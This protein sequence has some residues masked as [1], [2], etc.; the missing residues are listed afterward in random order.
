MFYFVFF[1]DLI[2][3]CVEHINTDDVIGYSFDL[4]N[5]MQWIL[6]NV[7][8]IIIERCHVLF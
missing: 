1:V 6:I 4:M 8:L 5:K 3:F 2:N 7:T